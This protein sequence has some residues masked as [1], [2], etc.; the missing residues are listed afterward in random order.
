MPAPVLYAE[1]VSTAVAVVARRAPGFQVATAGQH[2]LPS[3]PHVQ[4]FGYLQAEHIA[5]NE[6]LAGLAH[7]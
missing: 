7:G 5:E 6:I 4:C 2:P 3:R 1:A